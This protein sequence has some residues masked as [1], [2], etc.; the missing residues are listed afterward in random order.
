M[1]PAE[2]VR[3]GTLTE[4]QVDEALALLARFGGNTRRTAAELEKRGTPVAQQTL[5]DW[6][7]TTYFDR[8][9]EIAAAF[10]RESKDRAIVQGFREMLQEGQDISAE[11]RQRL[12]DGI[13]SIEAKDIPKALQQ[14]HVAMGIATE[15][16]LLL[17]GRPTEIRETRNPDWFEE[18]LKEL[19][20][21]AEITVDGT[22]VEE[23]PEAE[24]ERP[25]PEGRSGA[26]ATSPESVGQTRDPSAADHS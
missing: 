13:D 7:R 23:N 2:L 18:R 4:E 11:L 8:Y 12:Q 1:A 10:A 19:A 9:H 14:L 24:S 21:E 17:E 20:R 5:S 26:T 25:E 3:H 15:K 6:K 22:Y 16:T